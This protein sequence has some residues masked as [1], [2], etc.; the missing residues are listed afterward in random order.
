MGGLEFYKRG[1]NGLEVIVIMVLV[2]FK[3]ENNLVAFMVINQVVLINVPF[4]SCDLRSPLIRFIE[5]DLVADA[6]EESQIHDGNSFSV[7]KNN[8]L[9]HIHQNLLS[10][11]FFMNNG[12]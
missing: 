7:L 10:V 4:V 11:E 9:A 2:A 12:F 6:I 3:T 8:S 5:L 1:I